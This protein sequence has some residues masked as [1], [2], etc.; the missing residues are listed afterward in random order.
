M[1]CLPQ[2]CC[3]LRRRRLDAKPVFERVEFTMHVAAGG[4]LREVHIY[5]AMA[6]CAGSTYDVKSFG[7]ETRQRVLQKITY[8]AV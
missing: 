8:G 7:V 1:F 6:A 5:L 2:S 3:V 4:V